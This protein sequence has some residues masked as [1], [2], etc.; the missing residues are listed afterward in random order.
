MATSE[1]AER[2]AW[3]VA[4]QSAS[5]PARAAFLTATPVDALPGLA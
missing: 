3:R 5:G 2:M 4:S 1:K